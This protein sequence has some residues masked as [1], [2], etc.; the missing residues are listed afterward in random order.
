MQARWIGNDIAKGARFHTPGDI[1]RG[2]ENYHNALMVCCPHCGQLEIV[3]TTDPNRLCWGWD[4]STLT[5][6]PSYHIKHHDGLICH[7]TL[8]NGIFTVAPDSVKP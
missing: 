7:W 6:H 4:Q 2:T 1:G 8:V 5:L 3:N